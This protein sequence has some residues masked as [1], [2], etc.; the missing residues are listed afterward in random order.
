MKVIIVGGGISGMATAWELAQQMQRAKAGALVTL[1]EAGD[2][3]R[4]GATWASAGLLAPHVL[5]ADEPHAEARTKLIMASHALWADY[6]RELQAAS[7]ID[8]G[9]RTDGSLVT[10]WDSESGERL[11]GYYERQQRWGVE[12]KWLTGDEARAIEPELTENITA[13]VLSPIDHQV[14]NRLVGKALREAITRA[15]VTLREHATVEEIRIEGDRV[16]GVR[17]LGETLDADAVVLAAGA[18]SRSIA[19]LPEGIRPPVRPV[20]GQILALQMPPDKPLI[21]HLVWGGGVYIIPR[22]SG[23]VVIGAT[24][25]EQG[26][27]TQ[28]TAGGVMRLLRSACEAIPAFADLPIAETWAGLRPGSADDTPILG[29]TGVRGLTLATGHFAHGI[30]LAP[31]TAQTISHVVLTGETPAEIAAFGIGRFKG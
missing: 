19:G 13:A 11:K 15:G 27:D 23:R 30:V 9:Y 21:K 16:T 5:E 17:V 8:V 31:I 28:N 25:E 3:G 20:K 12:V 14:E 22:N 26:F 2:A 24:V 1:V 29:A 10:A 4:M 18:W 6:A 7:G